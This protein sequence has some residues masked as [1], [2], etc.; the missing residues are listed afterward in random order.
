MTVR[1][2]LVAPLAVSA[3][4]TSHAG[5]QSWRTLDVSRQLADS[6][7]AT[8][9]VVYGTGGIGIRATSN[10]L[11]YHMQ[12]RYDATRTQPRHVFDARSRK[13]DIGVQSSE[14]RFTDRKDGTSGHLQLELSRSIPL[15]VDLDLGAVEADLDL[16]GLRLAKFKLESGASDAKLR[17]DSLNAVPMSELQISLGAASFRGDRLANANAKEIRVEAG[18][19]NVELDLGGQWTRD[20][21]LRID[22]TLGIVT[23]HVPAD[24]GVRLSL[25]KT[26]TS[27]EHEGL[28]E[29]DGAWV[30][31]NWE[32][33]PHKLRV[34]AE[35]T[36]GKLTIDRTGR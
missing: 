22:V 16:T 7:S 12:L 13:L 4:V 29:R 19:G 9:R 3:L 25:E 18:V 6:N 1:R 21:D 34:N 15:D 17:F 32:S 10:P 26:L 24:V 2:R 35:T 30:S 11:L 20:I 5:A 31:R 14:M 33:A 36:F 28:I 23:I 27:F 8:V